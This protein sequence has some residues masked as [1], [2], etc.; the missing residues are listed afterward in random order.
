MAETADTPKINLGVKEGAGA[1]H[2]GILVE[3]VKKFGSAGRAGIQAGDEIV[4][5]ND[6][7]ISSLAEA[8]AMLNALGA[9][10]KAK[11]ALMRGGQQ[12]AVEMA[13]RAKKSLKLDLEEVDEVLERKI[14][15]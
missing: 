11:V 1:A 13:L 14:S 12:V 6:Q 8:E 5:I 15:P 10:A 3:S 9:G 4:A 2:G 7:K